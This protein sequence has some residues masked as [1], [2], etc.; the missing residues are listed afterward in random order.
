MSALSK[1]LR[2]EISGI[3]ARHV[4]SV[5]GDVRKV[6]SELVAAV[7]VL[8]ETVEVLKADIRVLKQSTPAPIPKGPLVSDEEL[9]KFHVTGKLVKQMRQKLDLSQR[10]LG[11]LL[12]VSSQAVYLWER[13]DGAL[14]LRRKALKAVYLV[15]ELTIEEARRRVIELEARLPVEE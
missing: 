7:K 6:Q 10:E 11:I 15:R 8:Q 14:L 2:E 12:G 5:C 1:V 9:R 3:A 4:Q 13:T